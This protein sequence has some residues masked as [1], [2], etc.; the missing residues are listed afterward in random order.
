M[1][2]YTVSVTRQSDPQFVSFPFRFEATIH[3]PADEVWAQWVETVTN[4]RESW[5]WPTQYSQPTV[6][7]SPPRAGGRLTLTYQIPNPNN[8]D[9]PKKNATYEFD[10]LEW[11]DMARAFS[12]RATPEHP[13]LAGG[14]HLSVSVIDDRHCRFVWAGEYKHVNQHEGKEAQGDVFAYFLCMFFTAMAQN[15]KKKVGYDDAPAPTTPG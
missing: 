8:P 2:N 4:Y 11:D 15:I 3:L 13:F 14:G 12:Y 6:D 5:L 9:G 1:H 10:L 7:Q